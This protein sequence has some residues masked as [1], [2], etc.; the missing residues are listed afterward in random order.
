MKAKKSVKKARTKSAGQI[1][2]RQI[3]CPGVRMFR[4]SQLKPADY[5][6][7]VIAAEALEGLM[8]SISRFGCVEPIVV[9]TR[10]RKNVIVGHR[11]T[12]TK[13]TRAPGTNN[14]ITF[15]CHLLCE[16]LSR[17]NWSY[18][19]TVRCP[20]C[21]SDKATV[22]NTKPPAGVNRIRYHKC[23]ECGLNFK[24]FERISK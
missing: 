9:N 17:S 21:R 1:A 22:Q 5:N 4:L 2:A 16:R 24:S 23:S 10:G 8:N 3:G 6:P 20:G 11:V 15:R 13:R 7:R 14:L 12:A 19:V 18:H